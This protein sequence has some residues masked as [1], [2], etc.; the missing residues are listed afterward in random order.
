MTMSDKRKTT[1][2]D[3]KRAPAFLSTA[4]RFYGEAFGS[5]TRREYLESLADWSELSEDDQAFTLAHLQYLNLL[6]QAG[7]QKLLV[8]VRD[9]LDEVAEGLGDVLD[10]DD[11]DDGDD[12]Y[13]GEDHLPPEIEELADQEAPLDD[14]PDEAGGQEP[15]GKPEAALTDEQAKS[16][17][18]TA[19]A[20]L[21]ALKDQAEHGSASDTIGQDA[22]GEE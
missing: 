6:A 17:L 19:V 16:A 3:K 18:A 20:R 2:R 15:H 13:E 10:P 1:K 7:T 8:Q 9:L 21:E 14:E 22:E 4:R 12:G 11:E 5:R